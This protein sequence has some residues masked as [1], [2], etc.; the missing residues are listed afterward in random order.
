MVGTD[1]AV[2]GIRLRRPGGYKFAVKDGRDGLFLPAGAEAAGGP[3][4]ICEG[5]TDAAALIDMGF[6]AGAVAG[7][8]SCT[9][10]VKLLCELVRRRRPL[11]VVVLADGDEP[12]RRGAANLASVLLAY[13]PAVR[14]IAPPEGVKDA[15]EWLRAGGTRRDAEAAI[16]AAP[17]RRLSVRATVRKGWKG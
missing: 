14:V 4:L 10:G 11:E 8:P 13:A 5:P 16:Q 17:A 7:R 2:R 15:R 9:G 12:G 6:G 3:L 1:G